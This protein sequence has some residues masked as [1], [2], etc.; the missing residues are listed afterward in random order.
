[1]DANHQFLGDDERQFVNPADARRQKDRES[2]F[3]MAPKIVF[4]NDSV[5]RRQKGVDLTS[6]PFGAQPL[7]LLRP[8]ILEPDRI[9][10]DFATRNMG[11]QIERNCRLRIVGK[12][13]VQVFFEKHR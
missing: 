12:Q 11:R 2:D 3:L 5:D 9:L 4:L 13:F 6:P 10:A 7:R 1:M 8:Q